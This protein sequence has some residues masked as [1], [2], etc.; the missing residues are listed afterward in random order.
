MMPGERRSV[1]NKGN[2]RVLLLIASE[3]ILCVFRVYLTSI[4]HLTQFVFVELRRPF[5][6]DCGFFT[7]LI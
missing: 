2:R 7:F 6:N 5:R 3:L 1:L 4:M